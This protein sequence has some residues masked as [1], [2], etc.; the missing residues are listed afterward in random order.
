MRIVNVFSAVMVALIA[1]ATVSMAQSAGVVG[2]KY[3]S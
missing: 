1:S 2:K 3:E